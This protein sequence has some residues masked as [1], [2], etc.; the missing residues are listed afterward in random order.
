[1]R[2]KEKEYSKVITYSMFSNVPVIKE[3]ESK[4][5]GV[6]TV[7]YEIMGEETRIDRYNTQQIQ[8]RDTDKCCTLLPASIRSH[9]R[10]TTDA[11]K[12]YR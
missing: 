1:M 6:G 3:N 8:R 2:K 12:R 7:A 10:Y 5:S 4:W 11:E 9:N